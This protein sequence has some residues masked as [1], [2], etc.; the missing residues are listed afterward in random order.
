[1]GPRATWG[2]PHRARAARGAIGQPK[3]DGHNIAVGADKGTTAAMAAL[4]RARCSRD[5]DSSK[6]LQA[7]QGR[8]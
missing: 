4:G 2:R 8:R 6:E 5:P 3:R 1:M 7:M